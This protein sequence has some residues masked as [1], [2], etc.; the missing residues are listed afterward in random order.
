MPVPPFTAFWGPFLKALDDGDIHRVTDLA[1]VLAEYFQLSNEERS[2][3]ISSGRTR[4]L[5]R[6]LWTSTYLSQAG[7]VE[8]TSRG[9]VR[10]TER[11]RAVLRESPL[12]LDKAR[13]LEFPEFRSFAIKDGA[14][15]KRRSNKRVRDDN[16][17]SQLIIALD[18][19]PEEL[20]QRHHTELQD[21]VA[22]EIL[23]RV[24]RHSSRFF[25]RLVIELLVAMGYG[26]TREDAARV[27]GKS[28]DGGIDGVIKEDRLGLDEARS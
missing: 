13:L 25:E 14:V 26:G 11:G 5:D 6:A 10:I 16:A 9:N 17:D 18:V 1:G 22:A 2:E 12:R 28:G 27:I 7:L 24:K 4:V 19:S 15:E 21:A 8:R 23:L 3:R 20:I